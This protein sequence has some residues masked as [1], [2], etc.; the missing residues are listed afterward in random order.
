MIDAV[1]ISAIA[2]AFLLGGVVKGVIGLGLPT[3]SLA[4]LAVTI[5]LTS[6]MALILVPSILTNVWQ[7]LF[8][9]NVKLILARLWPFLIMATITVWIGAIALTRINLSLLSA[10]LGLLLVIYSAVNLGGVHFRIP[11]RHETW[12]GLVT[13]S[14]NGVFTGMT[15]SSV[16]PGVMYL[17]SIGLSRD[18]LIQAMG[19]LFMLSTSA[20]AIALQQNAILT[21]ELGILSVAAL[22]PGIIGM[23]IG[24]RIRLNLSEILF[25][26]VF[27]VSLLLLGIYII[28]T[29]FLAST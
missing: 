8:G 5:D 29:A 11:A 23:I 2:V 16:V 3:V 26:K 7:S 18:V 28:A 20:L 10:L 17:Q 15:G 12:L 13:G 27:F 14:L 25:R 19:I 6:A 9:G 1:T 24:Q 21:L 22:I 4:L